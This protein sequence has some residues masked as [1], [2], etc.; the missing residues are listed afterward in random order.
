MQSTGR[1]VAP[2]SVQ[3]A[4][5]DKNGSSP[6][7]VCAGAPSDSWRLRKGGRR[8]ICPKQTF[9]PS[10]PNCFPDLMNSSPRTRCFPGLWLHEHK[11]YCLNSH[12]RLP[13]YFHE[14][15]TVFAASDR[16]HHPAAL[17]SSLSLIRFLPR[18]GMRVQLPALILLALT[19]KGASSYWFVCSS[20]WIACRFFVLFCFVFWGSYGA[21][22][23][24]SV[25]HWCTFCV[26]VS[27]KC[28]DNF[29]FMMTLLSFPGLLLYSFPPFNYEAVFRFV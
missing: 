1:L 24:P 28:H 18:S 10:S 21:S 17:C 5:S 12:I 29:H 4:V 22:L 6:Q 13:N 19:S 11:D 2:A 14:C 26:N 3:T 16:T 23:L 7:Q 25:L 8:K 27:S 15:C 20:L 9:F